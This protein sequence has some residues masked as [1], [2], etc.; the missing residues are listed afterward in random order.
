[1]K[2]VLLHSNK[3]CEIYKFRILGRI[4]IILSMAMSMVRS[5]AVVM[6]AVWSMVI[7]GIERL[8]GWQPGKQEPLILPRMKFNNLT[9]QSRKPWPLIL[10]GMKFSNLTK[11]SLSA[12][13]RNQH[14]SVFKWR[15]KQYR[16]I[17]LFYV[18]HLITLK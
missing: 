12:E 7:T 6:S 2:G 9:E 5:I 14:V 17:K 13:I 18:L 1:M 3:A 4:T 10:P 8:V 15:P 16:F 11:Q